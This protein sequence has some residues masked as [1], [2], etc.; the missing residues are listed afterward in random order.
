MTSQEFG[1]WLKS[2]REARGLTAKEAAKAFGCTRTAW[3]AWESGLV[4][5]QGRFMVPIARRWMVPE[6]F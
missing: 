3:H 4:V 6:R 5:P 1:K 2:E